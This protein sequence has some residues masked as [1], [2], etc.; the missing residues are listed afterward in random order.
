MRRIILDNVWYYGF[1]FLSFLSGVI[2][3]TLYFFRK[4]EM[5]RIRWIEV[6]HDLAKAE[7]RS[8]RDI[9]LL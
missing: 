5:W 2:L 6:E 8:P 1:L 7:H 3:T 4:I 9:D